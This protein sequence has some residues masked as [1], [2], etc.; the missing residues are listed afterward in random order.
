M[1]GGKSSGAVHIK[2]TFKCRMYLKELM[3]DF[4]IAGGR[5][6]FR[7]II[8]GRRENDSGRICG[9]EACISHPCERRKIICR[10]RRESEKKRLQ[11]GAFP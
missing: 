2:V 7:S 1:I 8:P 11:Y 5:S 6:K 10:L 3:K 4:C 9:A